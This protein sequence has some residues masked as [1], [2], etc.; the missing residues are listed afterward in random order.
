MENK[1]YSSEPESRSSVV[2]NSAARARKMLRSTRRMLQ[3]VSSEADSNGKL[4]L[5]R[6]T[7]QVAEASGV[8]F[9]LEHESKS[10]FDCLAGAVRARDHLRTAL[11]ALQ[12]PEMAGSFPVECAEAV[13][14]ALAI[15]FSAAKGQD[16]Q[17]QDRLRE[18]SHK[19]TERRAENNDS[20]VPIALSRRRGA[21]NKAPEVLAPQAEVALE[22]RQADRVLLEADVGLVSES[23]FYA[24]L[25]MDL[26]VGGVFIATY[27]RKPIGAPVALSLVLPGGHLVWAKGVVRWIREA[28]GDENVPGIGVEFTEVEPADMKAI[29]QFCKMRAPLLFDADDV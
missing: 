8:L 2:R 3:E 13:A 27:Q 22:R 17:E 21:S 19:A 23:Q 16:W 1:Q 15:V 11:S 4:R 28:A 26:S 18:A 5:A 10:D 25:S 29:R 14:S 6:A 9:E 20:M 24:G 12:A 7:E